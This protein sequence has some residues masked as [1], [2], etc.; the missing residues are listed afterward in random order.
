M[1]WTFQLFQRHN[2]RVGEPSVAMNFG[3][4]VSTES[5]DEGAVQSKETDRGEVG[6]P[7]LSTV[8]GSNRAPAL[9]VLNALSLDSLGIRQ[10][11]YADGK[12]FEFCQ[13]RRSQATRPGYNLVLT[14]LQFPYQKRC[15]NP[16]RLEAGR[17][18]CRSP[19]CARRQQTE[20]QTWRCPL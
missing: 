15:Q 14:F 5:P 7:A 20:Y 12:F 9:Q 10:L 6:P 16:L 3:V 2:E 4:K 13:F 8:V 19:F 1:R 17:L 11:D 18:L